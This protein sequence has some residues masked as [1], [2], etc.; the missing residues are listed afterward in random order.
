MSDEIDIS[1]LHG[2]IKAYA[3]YADRDNNPNSSGYNKLNTRY[4]LSAFKDMIIRDGLQEELKRQLPY[5]KGVTV[6]IKKAK[7]EEDVNRRILDYMRGNKEVSDHEE[8]R[9]LV[10]E[11]NEI[12][13]DKYDVDE[14][15]HD[16][17]K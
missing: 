14:D 7:K 6:P 1:K 15:T 2:K 8:M 4:E 10:S 12:K 16:E 9:A 5:M 3:K 13:K 17:N 11:R